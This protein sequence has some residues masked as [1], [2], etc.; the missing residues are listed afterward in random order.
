MLHDPGSYAPPQRFMEIRLKPKE[1]DVLRALAGEWAAIAALP[2]H[3][4]K[5]ELW[6]RLND[7]DSVRP[8]VWINEIPWHEMDVDGELSL[9]TEHPWARELETRLRRALY[10]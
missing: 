7:L 3:R 2:V 9:R 4:E 6:R 10:Q 8:M 5:A 1:K